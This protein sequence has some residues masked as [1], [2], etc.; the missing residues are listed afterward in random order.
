MNKSLLTIALC[1]ASLWAG[2]A[3]AQESK[4]AVRTMKVSMAK[5]INGVETRVDT[6]ITLQ[7]GQD[8]NEVL[9]SLGMNTD[10]LRIPEISTDGPAT[11]RQTDVDIQ[12]GGEGAKKIVIVRDG[13]NQVMELNE[14][15]NWTTPDGQVIELSSGQVNFIG[16]DGEHRVIRVV[17]GEGKT[18][19]VNV[20]A[21]GDSLMPRVVILQ[22]SV[23]GAEGLDSMQWQMDNGQIIMMKENP[24]SRHFEAEETERVEIRMGRTM[25]GSDSLRTIVRE[26]SI[27]VIR[28][29]KATKADLDMLRESGAE[30][31]NNKLALD[32]L[33][34]YPNPGNGIFDL[35]FRS[36]EEG[37]LLIEVRDLQGR[38][39]YE[40]SLSNFRGYFQDDLDLSGASSG[41]YF[42]TI[43]VG[44]RSATKKLIVE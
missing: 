42:L 37:D 26:T 31:L 27:V 41:I 17:D 22:K 28:L 43:R 3:F 29:E 32:D 34:V 38:L 16:E 25:E 30:N 9:R 35:S 4:P 10:E 39:T 18:I 15:G 6:T 14:Q 40:R 12:Y 20:D 23:E 13:Q 1:A 8:P 11:Y 19:E 36:R 21:S 2:A 24:G 33:V 44:D 7:P 5:N